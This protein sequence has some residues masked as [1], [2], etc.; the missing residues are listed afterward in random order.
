M[1]FSIDQEQRCFGFDA[2]G[3]KKQNDK[4]YHRT[5]RESEKGRGCYLH[6][7]KAAAFSPGS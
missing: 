2:V 4:D 1:G 5:H 3:V 7:A 6:I